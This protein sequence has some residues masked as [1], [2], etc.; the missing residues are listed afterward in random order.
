MQEI[1]RENNFKKLATTKSQ[2]LQ[3]T[4]QDLVDQIQNL[5]DKQQARLKQN[6]TDEVKK[7]VKEEVKNQTSQAL[8]MTKIESLNSKLDTAITQQ[9]TLISLL[10]YQA[11]DQNGQLQ[12][13]SYLSQISQYFTQ[14]ISSL[15][16]SKLP[17]ES[18]VKN[19]NKSLEEM[20][21]SIEKLASTITGTL[22][23]IDPETGKIVQDLAND[24]TKKQTK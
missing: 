5:F 10:S 24:N 15:S 2:N 11:V 22:L 14:L 3:K 19:V 18:S 16:L 21:S 12:K 17:D 13:Y 9:E 6:L 23:A 20:K 1:S 8:D 4:S 7:T